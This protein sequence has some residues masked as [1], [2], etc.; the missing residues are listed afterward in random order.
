MCVCVFVPSSWQ[1]NMGFSSVRFGSCTF[2]AH[3]HTDRKKKHTVN[4]A[5]QKHIM[6][7]CMILITS[8]LNFTLNADPVYN[9]RKNVSASAN[10]LTKNPM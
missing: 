3:A 2:Q 6:F 1:A 7:S 9:Q 5:T 4:M 10:A 8:H